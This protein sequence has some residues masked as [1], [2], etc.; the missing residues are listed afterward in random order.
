MRCTLCGDRV[1]ECRMRDHLE[2]HSAHAENLSWEE[3]RNTFVMEEEHAEE[4]SE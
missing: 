2:E 4:E 1:A 3:V